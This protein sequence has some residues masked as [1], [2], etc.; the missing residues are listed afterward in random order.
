M[1]WYKTTVTAHGP[2]CV[3]AVCRLGVGRRPLRPTRCRRPPGA[4]GSREV[5]A[6]AGLLVPRL[7]PDVAD[8]DHLVL[9]GLA[10]PAAPRPRA[11]PAL[12]DLPGRDNVG[13]RPSVTWLD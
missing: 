13:V 6:P 7:Q 1:P 11:V 10:P 5:A 4:G 3:S 9:A 12:A 2:T 8:A